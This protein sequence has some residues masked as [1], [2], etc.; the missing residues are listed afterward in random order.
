MTVRRWSAPETSDASTASTTPHWQEAARAPLRLRMLR[1]LPRLESSPGAFLYS[2]PSPP[3]KL[4]PLLPTE[5]P[6][7]ATIDPIAP[8]DAAPAA[9]HESP[10]PAPPAGAGR[11]GGE[12]R[13]G[14]G[15]GDSLTWRTSS[16]PSPLD[17]PGEWDELERAALQACGIART[18]SQP[19]VVQRRRRTGSICMPG[20]KQTSFRAPL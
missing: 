18:P 14:W 16:S 7:P 10:A 6:P 1:P 15:S 8:A 2:A 20:A 3:C 4:P 9:R 11:R 12:G 17:M 19:S 5:A 13:S